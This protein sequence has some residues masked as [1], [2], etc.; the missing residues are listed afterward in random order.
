[1]VGEE[2]QPNL[3]LNITVIT[4]QSPADHGALHPRTT[5]E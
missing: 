1:V 3:I 5:T 4:R 2:G